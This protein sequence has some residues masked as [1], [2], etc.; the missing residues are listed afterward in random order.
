MSPSRPAPPKSGQNHAITD[1]LQRGLALHQ[2]GRGAEAA[3]LYQQVLARDPRQPAANHLLGLV[4]LQQGRADEAVSHIATAVSASPKEAQYLGNLGVALNAAGRNEEAAVALRRAVAFNPQFAEAYS[5]LGMALR[6]LGQTG[7]AI[8]AYH[9]A[10]RLKPMEAGFHF[11]LGNSLRD[12]GDIIEAESAYRR[13]IAFRPNYSPAINALAVVLDDEGRSGEALDLVE[14]ALLALPNDAQLHLRRARSLRHQHRLEAALAS[15]DRAVELNPGFGEAHLQRSYA[16]RH[17]T[18]DASIDAMEQLF[19]AET[20]P[21][22][23]RIFAGFG[24]GK[25]LTD[26]GEHRQAIEIFTEANRMLRAR[27]PFSL[28]QAAADL[29]AEV[30]RFEGVPPPTADAGFR[31]DAPIFVVG[32]PRSGKTTIEAI[33]ARHPGV[34]GA[35]ELP[36]MGR[37]VR[38]LLADHPNASAR[39]VP[40]ERFTELGRAYMLE[41]QRFV[42][43]GRIPVDTM[44]S[45]YRH[46]GFIRLALPNARI[47]VARRPPPEHCVAIFEKYLTGRG[48]EYANDMDELQPYHAAFRRLI[49]AWQSRFPGQLKDIDL[50]RVAA[51][52]EGEVR[53]LLEFC[54]LGW[55]PACLAETRSEPQHRDWSLDRVAHNH[56]DH[57]AAWRRFRPQLWD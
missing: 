20:A 45:N 9:S 49:D 19:V 12:A 40:P 32:L 10:V 53:K 14:P 56:A 50:G 54:G 39:D 27:T 43:A 17:E 11:N 1:L 48:Y 6:A 5:N 30:D 25:A 57:I 8:G 2:A 46:V 24:L 22:D 15:F 28:E 29:R 26:L 35:G 51:D 3:T 41:V 31:E 55:D 38:D 52:R 44:P 7:E 33:L 4:F 42:P 47:V 16:M 36:T 34:S 23:D 37:L 18:R 21:I 13:A